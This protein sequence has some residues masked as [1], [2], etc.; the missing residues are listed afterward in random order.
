VLRTAHKVCL[1]LGIDHATIQVQDA[2]DEGFCFSQSC[3]SHNPDAGQ[4]KAS[5][6]VLSNHLE[7]SSGSA[8][9]GGGAKQQSK[10]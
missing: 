10:K 3:D 9:T 1:K 5:S 4:S 7:V 2:T 8:K 6:C